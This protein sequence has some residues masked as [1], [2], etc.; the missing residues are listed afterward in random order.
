MDDIITTLKEIHRRVKPQI[1]K[2]ME[3]FRRN[4]T[5]EKIAKELFFCLLTPQCKA[6]VCWKNVEY[7]YSKGILQKGNEKEIAESLYGIRFRNNKACY[8]VEARE[9][10]FNGGCSLR[11]IIKVTEDTFSL[12]EYLVAN[13]KGMGWKEASHFLRNIGMGENFAILDRHILK[14][15][16]KAKVVEKVPNTTIGKIYIEVED[17][18]RKFSKKIDIPLS[19]LDFVFW[20]FFNEEVFK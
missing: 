15:L 18:M 20:Y 14:G 1:E 16:V 17:K 6:K 4:N 3:E 13:V 11:E 2:R 10:F 7:L 8:I 9:K 5:D 12:R 19:H